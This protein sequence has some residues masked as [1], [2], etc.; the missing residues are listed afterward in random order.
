MR[1]PLPFAEIINYLKSIE[2][3]SQKH[4]KTLERIEQVQ[5][6]DHKDAREMERRLA[7]VETELKTMSELIA[8]IPNQTRDRVAEASEPIIESA[9]NLTDAINEKDV[10]QINKPIKKKPFWKF[11]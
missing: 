10:V 11:W 4:E 9:A 8:K 7:H 5:D 3:R 6:I 1:L 2:E